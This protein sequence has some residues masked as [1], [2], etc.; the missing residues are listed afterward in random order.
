[1]T[2]YC[3]GVCASHPHL[4]PIGTVFVIPV[5]RG[6]TGDTHRLDTSRWRVVNHAWCQVGA[7]AEWLETIEIVPEE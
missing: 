5:E 7:R 1:L 3:D 6:G 4:R 2:T